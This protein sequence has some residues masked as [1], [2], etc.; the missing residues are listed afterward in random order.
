LEALIGLRQEIFRNLSGQGVSD[1]READ[2]ALRQV[3]PALLEP[4]MHSTGVKDFLARVRIRPVGSEVSRA[5]NPAQQVLKIVREE[6]AATLGPIAPWNLYG[7]KPRVVLLA[8]LQGSGKTTTAAK[9]AA[10]LRADGE[11]VLLAATDIHRPAAVRRFRC[12]T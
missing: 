9:L 4:D 1:E 3:R 6:L 10:E 11:R 12:G 7:P 2:S 5:L 8:G